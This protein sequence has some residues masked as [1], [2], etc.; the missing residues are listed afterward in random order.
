MIFT[1]SLGGDFY[2]YREGVIAMLTDPYGCGIPGSNEKMVTNIDSSFGG[3]LEQGVPK[4][5][6]GTTRSGVGGLSHDFFL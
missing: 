6:K 2:A 3:G 1:E 4:H 5:G